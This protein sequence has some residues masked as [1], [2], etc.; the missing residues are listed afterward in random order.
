M[1]RHMLLAMD[2]PRH[3][4]LPP[5]AAPTA[6][7]R[8]VIADLEPQIRSICRE[9]MDD[10]AERGEVEFVHDVTSGLPTQV[11]GR[12]HGPPR[13]GLGLIHRLG[14]AAA[15]AARTPRSAGDA[16]PTA[17]SM[18]MA[19]YAIEL[20][21]RRRAEPPREDLTTLHPRGGLRRAA[22]ERHRLRQLLRAAGDRRQRHHQD[23]AVVGAARAAAAP[24]PARRGARRTAR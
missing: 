2:P 16:G 5:P 15:P 21:A 17:P 3:V 18:E 11:I 7:R 1:M 19:M 22:D 14:R 23:D 9:I 13:G 12:A 10:A 4:E 8:K 24:R 20:A 6:S